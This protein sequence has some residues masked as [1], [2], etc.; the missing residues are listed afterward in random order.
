VNNLDEE[1]RKKTVQAIRLLI[2]EP[3]QGKSA[4]IESILKKSETNF[5]I[6]VCRDAVGAKAVVDDKRTWFDVVLSAI[7]LPD[8]SGTRLC[9]TLRDKH[10][11]P[12]CYLM[13]DSGQEEQAAEALV[14]GA[15]QVLIRDPENLF[16][17]MLPQLIDRTVQRKRAIEITTSDHMATL[18]MSD[19]ASE[20][21]KT[22]DTILRETEP[23]WRAMQVNPFEYFLLVDKTGL[24]K[25][26]N[27]M[28]EGYEF[29]TVIGKVTVYDFAEAKMKDGIRAKLETVFSTGRSVLYEF[30]S[31]QLDQWFF[32]TA[33][34]VYKK[35][36]VIGAA[37]FGHD[38]TE[39]KQ[40]E[41]NLIVS[42]KRF[43]E[44]TETIRDV[45]YVLNADTFEAIYVSPA[46]EEIYGL[47]RDKVY[48]RPGVW[49]DT[50][51][52]E[53]R[54]IIVERQ[55]QLKKK[56]PD[57]YVGPEHRVV[58]PDGKIRWI[59][60]RSFLVR[61][62]AGENDR[63][64]GVVKDITARKEAE[65]NLL[66]TTSRM[67]AFFSTFPDLMFII[68]RDGTVLD[69]RAGETK[70]L[71]RTPNQFLGKK[72][73]DLLPPDVGGKVDDALT[74]VRRT[75]M[76]QSIEYWL[77][78][79]LGHKAFESRLI[80]I[81]ETRIAVIVRDITDRKTAEKN[82]KQAHVELERRILERTRALNTINEELRQ[83][84]IARKETEAAFRRAEKLASIGTLAAGIAHEINNPLGSI[85]M[86]A[87]NALYS[88]EHPEE[89]ADAVGALV[90]IKDEAKRAGKIVKT[91]LQF[92]QKDESQ[93]ELH[94]MGSIVRRACKICFDIASERGVVINADIPKDLPAT[95]MNPSEMEQVFVNLISN[96]IEASETDQ[97]VTIRFHVK[98]NVLEVT[99]VDNGCGMTKEQIRRIFDPFF[100]TR[101]TEG[102]TGLGLS[103]AHTIVRHH[104]GTINVSSEPGAGTQFSVSLPVCGETKDDEGTNP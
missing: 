58:Q 101:Q 93:R 26:I 23:L 29:D 20:E 82:L 37:I 43:R 57:R 40:A 79:P 35:G 48:A 65:Q 2:I 32:N 22:A 10:T 67:E 71:Y 52:P 92:A 61:N 34:P 6:T 78:V 30:Y 66:E 68:D 21:Y 99:V 38:I 84:M 63:V 88:V 56:F 28:V 8:S 54:K 9:T 36:Q 80:G 16:L 50:V 31:P 5:E 94:D 74:E 72:M 59:Q 76:P 81:D 18:I 90:D 14:K 64:I 1:T 39:K 42:E 53:D 3:D 77:D 91:V 62:E 11:I 44:V 69:F 89:L 98:V 17:Q 27:R 19:P 96:A 15:D 51:H 86:A 75:K 87:D 7:T 83:E 100:T 41:K 60:N 95:K 13:F 97:S 104:E 49:L 12:V 102:G 73:Q 70:N 45:F 85:L 47:P 25:H 24:L 55:K 46:F 33:S 4:L 103:L